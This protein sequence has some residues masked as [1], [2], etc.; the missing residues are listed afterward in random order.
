[1]AWRDVPEEQRQRVFDLL[2]AEASRLERE[3]VQMQQAAER[4]GRPSLVDRQELGANA[5]REAIEALRDL[6]S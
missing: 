6:G 2:L 5:F 1:M 4:L 3:A